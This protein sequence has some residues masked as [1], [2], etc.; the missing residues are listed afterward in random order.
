MA[1]A[2]KPALEKLTPSAS[3]L[4]LQAY[5]QILTRFARLDAFASVSTLPSLSDVADR[6]VQLSQEDLVVFAIYLRHAVENA[7]IYKEMR[8]RTFN[9]FYADGLRLVSIVDVLN[10]I[11][12][13]RFLEVIRRESDFKR[14]MLNDDKGM[15]E[16]MEN[17]RK[18]VAPSVV[19][20][21][22]KGDMVAF[23]LAKFLDA[24]ADQIIEPL[25]EYC[26]DRGLYLEYV[27]RV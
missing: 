24:V 21:S 3:E 26:Q 18:G 5:E 22:D 11:I 7:G 19:V 17:Y 10:V 20:M 4:I 6:Q 9:A 15:L 16:F 14:G 13:H 8:K 12:H 1:K 25:V 27:Y 2:K 23:R